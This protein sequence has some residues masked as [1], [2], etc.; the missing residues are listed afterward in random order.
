M[1]II[2]KGREGERNAI[3]TEKYSVVIKQTAKG[4]YYLGS[5]RIN[6]NTLDEMKTSLN[7]ALAMITKKIENLNTGKNNTNKQDSKQEISLNPEENKLYENLRHLRTELMVKENIPAYM[8]FHDSVLKQLTRHRHKTKE[9]MLAIP[10]IA[11]KKFEQYGEMFLIK[12]REFEKNK[13]K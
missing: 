8:I 12:I 7:I 13:N 1:E 10:G 9:E 2:N 3:N 5:L 11:D 4:L 6:A